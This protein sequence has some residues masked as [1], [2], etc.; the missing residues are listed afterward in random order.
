MVS[1]SQTD[2]EYSSKGMDVCPGKYN[3]KH[4]DLQN[5]CFFLFI[6]ATTGIGVLIV[7]ISFSVSLCRQ[8]DTIL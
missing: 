3:D 5:K 4:A 7:T 6:A 1:W 2:H 8:I